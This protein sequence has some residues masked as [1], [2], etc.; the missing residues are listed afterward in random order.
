MK[1]AGEVV[2]EMLGHGFY[3]LLF[4][5]T[6]KRIKI[7][8]LWPLKTS[9]IWWSTPGLGAAQEALVVGGGI[10]NGLILSFALQAF[11]LL[12]PRPWRYAVPL[13]WLAFW[14]YLSSTG[15]LI[16]GALGS[17]GDVGRLIGIGV[18]T[19]ASSFALGLALF[20]VGF[21]SISIIL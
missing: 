14:A 20:T 13:I 16:A 15:Y 12:R 21:V 4:G 1:I 8:L 17:F 5:G 2:H 11:L 19:L 6:N 18:L 3:V 7:S 10:L 9:Y